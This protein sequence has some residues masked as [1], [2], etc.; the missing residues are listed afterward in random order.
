[1]RKIMFMTNGLYG[2]G[3]EKILQIILQNIDYSKY[4]VTLYSM[5]REK[6]NTELY[7]SGVHYKSVFVPYEGTSKTGR[8]FHGFMEKVKGKILNIG[9]SSIV[10]SMAVKEKYDVEIAFIEGESTKIIA[11]STNK[12]SKKYS[13]VHIDL[14]NNPWTEF[15]YRNVNDE[16]KHYQKFDKI[17]CVS[18]SVKKSFITKFGL[19]ENVFTQ[20]NPIDCKK[21]LECA[22]ER[23]D[24]PEKKR[25][26]M[27]AVGRLVEQKGF[28]RL[29]RCVQRL[30][31]EKIDFELYILGEGKERGN[32][33]KFIS[34]NKL[35]DNVF[36]LGFHQNPYSY[37][38]NADLL[39]AP[40]RAE[41]FSTV[42]SEAIVLGL[43]VISTDCAGVRELFANE[44]CGIITENDE[45]AFYKALREVFENPVCLNTYR[46]A[47]ARRGKMFSLEMTMKEMEG[48][49][50]E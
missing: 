46:E 11:G 30:K 12:H 26:R 27:V 2:G 32:F 37:M 7:G 33:E 13:W 9:P 8:F 45:E 38:S 25:I 43:P 35:Y 47:S 50:D 44:K 5:H 42:V 1:M 49:F 6:L 19:S 34:E 23:C 29:L 10:Y 17:M 39:V 40:S 36:L 14:L 16:Q 3:A 48:L 41:G 15:L 18:D 28:D 20:Y 31:I 24:L 22:S 4:D 21:I